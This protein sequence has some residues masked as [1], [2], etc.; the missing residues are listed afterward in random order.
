MQTSEMYA[1]SNG[2]QSPG[3]NSISN[4]YE[5]GLDP[6]SCIIFGSDYQKND[7]I[8]KMLDSSKDNLKLLAMRR[9]IAMVARGKECSDLFAAVVKNVVSKDPE[10]KKLVYAY[11]VRYAEEQQDL[12][13][14][15]ISTF[16][17]SLKDANQLV[18]ASALRVLSSIRI[19]VIAPILMLALRD[20]SVDLSPYVR[21]TVALAI[22]KLY[23]LEPDE[24]ESL[25]EIISK[26]LEDK[27][28]AV[29]GSAVQAF[30]EICSERLDLIH[31][32]YRKLC[33]L[34]MDVDEWGQIAIIN[35]LTRYARTQFPDPKTCMASST[36]FS[37]KDDT[38]ISG[39]NKS[40]KV[41]KFTKLDECGKMSETEEDKDDEDNSLKEINAVNGISNLEHA[42]MLRSDYRLLITSCRLLLLSHNAAVVLAVAQLF[43]HC[44]SKEEMPAVVRALM[45]IL[46][47]SRE[48]EYVVLSNVASMS[49]IHPALFEPYI[50]MFFVFSS[51]SIHVKM[52]KLEVLT[53]LVST[54]TSPIILREFQAYVDSSDQEFVL[55][56]V[57]SIGRC[58]SM[59]PQISETCLRGLLRLMSRKNE[60]LVGESV[61]VMRKLLQMQ[62]TDHRDIILHLAQMVEEITI[63]SARASILWLLGE[64]G[65]R[66]PKIAPDVLRKMAK[67]F[68]KE[69]ISVKIQVL[70][71]AA[72]LC[73]VNPKQTLLLAQY[74][75]TLAKYDQ[76]YDIRDRSRMF[77]ALIFPKNADS[78]N[79]DAIFLAKNVKKILLATKPAPVL[80]STFA[81]RSQFR[82]GTMSQLLGR[83]ITNYVELPEWPEVPPDPTSRQVVIL[84]SG[85]YSASN[86][87]TEGRSFSISQQETEDETEESST[88]VETASTEEEESE[89]DESSEEGEQ[90]WDDGEEF[91]GKLKMGKNGV[92]SHKRDTPKTKPVCDTSSPE[93]GSHSP[94][95]IVSS[96]SSLETEDDDDDDEG[97]IKG[98]P[99]SSGKKK[100]NGTSVDLLLLDLDTPSVPSSE[101][102]VSALADPLIPTPVAISANLKSGSPA[103]QKPALPP[104]ESKIE[105][106]IPAYEIASP[107]WFYITSAYAEPLLVEGRFIRTVSVPPS[108][109]LQTDVELRLTNRSVAPAL[110]LLRLRTDESAFKG[111]GTFKS[112]HCVESFGEVTALNV[113]S[114]ANVFLGIDFCNSTQ[115]LCLNLRYQVEALDGD[116]GVASQEVEA[117]DEEGRKKPPLQEEILTLEIRP[118]V[119]ELF[120]PLNISPHEFVIKQASLRGM[121]ETNKSFTIP[122]PGDSKFLLTSIKQILKLANLALIGAFK[123][124]DSIHLRLAGVTTADSTCCLVEV[125]AKH[126]SNEGT[127]RVN[128]EAVALGIQLAEDF[129]DRY[130]LMQNTMNSS[131][132]SVNV[133]AVYRYDK[134]SNEDLPFEKGERL[135][136][137][138]RLTDGNWA[139]AKNGQGQ[140][141]LIPLNFVEDMSPP[142]WLHGK[143]SRDATESIMQAE[144]LGSF[145]VRE[146]GRFAGDY[147]LSVVAPDPFDSKLGNKSEA[148]VQHYHIYSVDGL[149]GVDSSRFFSLDKKDVFPSLRKLIEHYKVAD[150][151]L[152]HPLTEPI[153][154]TERI[155][156]QR[157]RDHHWVPRERLVFGQNIG[158]GE[159]GEVLRA[160]YDDREVA[161]KRYKASARLQLIYEAYVMS[162]LKHENLLALLG[163]TEDKEMTVTESAVSAAAAD[164]LSLSSS[165]LCLVTEFSPLGSLLAF[166]R[167]RGRTVITHSALL[168]F[169]T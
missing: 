9:I 102:A 10:I 153:F 60:S 117:Q 120:Q 74:V 86:Y 75:F 40:N 43:Y 33:S 72:K 8:V 58:A 97:G 109:H 169:A 85:S 154:D 115:P 20:G 105:L 125:T 4:D 37:S 89:E 121:H 104:G 159:F 156:L 94:L 157:L 71:L 36:H 129:Y 84:P 91:T 5:I 161:V 73:I 166:L 61:V 42:E 95:R 131:D 7:E 167:S 90:E 141:G 111:S 81:D 66:V 119:G 110:R 13:L 139:F 6:A 112:V 68:S 80:R 28:T 64:Y 165:T 124:S 59:V 136:I 88:E 113:G 63:P 45:R 145:L 160:R 57:Q 142:P 15:S 116:S 34:L 70:N 16:Q 62:T 69:H 106:E 122:S 135:T 49:L 39:S 78:S 100:E 12:A 47:T 79:P 132:R 51:D 168:S 147:T 146:S 25:I 130:V 114:S 128:T 144:P 150:R 23:S 1:E 18:R 54:A 137:L 2:F 32:H 35:M 3:M 93:A 96:E 151:G 143:I 149:D 118:T 133:I 138:R 38:T 19:P 107:E 155:C 55:A 17:R 48:I 158:H 148:P 140:T 26:L 50:R 14:L 67:T 44:A 77:R 162:Q 92:S 65:H 53:N 101:S 29:A 82:V 11:L 30:E 123:R 103:S 24:K 76:N 134:T 164:K 56:A 41:Q 126:D 27:S 163:I 21:K 87:S 83:E 52:L 46:R 98:P 108:S 22:P 152:A 31:R 99:V 127:L